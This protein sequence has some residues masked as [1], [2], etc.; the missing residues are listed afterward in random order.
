MLGLLDA[1]F[2]LNEYGC[3]CVRIRYHVPGTWC[4]VQDS[5]VSF[6]LIMKCFFFFF[7]CRSP[8]WTSGSPRMRCFLAISK[9]KTSDRDLSRWNLFGGHFG[10]TPVDI[11][12]LNPGTTCIF[13]GECLICCQGAIRFKNKIH[14]IDLIL[15]A[16]K[17]VPP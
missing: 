3:C 1:N 6:F 15:K 16:V 7:S 17:N 9:A 11:G 8:R 13:C 12:H 2:A 4:L 14:Q 5:V 10:G